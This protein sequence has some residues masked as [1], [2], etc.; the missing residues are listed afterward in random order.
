MLIL[1]Y[2]ALAVAVRIRQVLQLVGDVELPPPMLELAQA[3]QV[4]DLAQVDAELQQLTVSGSGAVR[5]PATKTGPLSHALCERGRM[6]MWVCNLTIVHA[7]CQQ[8][9]VNAMQC[10]C[11]ASHMPLKP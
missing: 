5:M 7:R 2:N 1:P 11:L 9:M 6:L 10:T 8:L 4:R 3:G